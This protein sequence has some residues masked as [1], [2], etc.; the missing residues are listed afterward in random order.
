MAGFDRIAFAIEHR[1]EGREVECSGAKEQ[2]A[3]IQVM[4]DEAKEA[5]AGIETGTLSQ[6]DALRL[7]FCEDDPAPADEE[8]LPE[9]LRGDAIPTQIDNEPPT[10]EA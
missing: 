8:P 4:L 7:C 1:A 6:A 9:T 2:I 5:I 10:I 3:E